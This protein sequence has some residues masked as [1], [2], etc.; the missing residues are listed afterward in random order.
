MPVVG[1]A[2]ALLGV[3]DIDSD[4]AN[5]FDADDQAGLERLVGWF[6]GAHRRHEAGSTTA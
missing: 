5:T 1:A 2:G 3:L 4:Q 6:A